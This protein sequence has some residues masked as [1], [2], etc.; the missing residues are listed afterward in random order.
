MGGTGYYLLHDHH[1]QQGILQSKDVGRLC[2]FSGY[3][4][5]WLMNCD[6]FPADY[7]ELWDIYEKYVSLHSAKLTAKLHAEKDENGK[8]LHGKKCAA[9]A[10]K[11]VHAE[12]D[13]DGKSLHAKKL[14]RVLHAVKDADGKSVNS[15]KGGKK[16]GVATHRYKDGFGRSVH[17]VKCAE[18]LH[19]EKDEGGGSLAAKKAGA[20]AKLVCQKKIELMRLSDKVTFV[21]ESGM[22]ACR[23]LGLNSGSLSNVCNGKYKS[24]KG[25]TARYLT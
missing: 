8:S 22:D 9:A 25:F 5:R 21:F 23:S 11:V 13:A 6:P 18:R 1:Q 19:A 2:V 16:G 17:G 10:H 7:F 20:A 24:T 3:A 14:G 4:K 12:K 15:V